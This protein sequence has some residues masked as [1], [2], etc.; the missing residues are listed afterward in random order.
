[1]NFRAG[2]RALLAVTAPLLLNT[3]ALSASEP[4]ALRFDVRAFEIEGSLPIPVDRSQAILV[5]FTG[6]AVGLEEL[7]AAAKALESELSAQG[8]V[9]YHVVL[10]PQT[11]GETVKLRVLPFALADVSVS[12]NK[13]FSNENVLASLPALKPGESPNVAAVARD[14][15]HSNEHPA[16]QVDVTFRQSQTPDSVDADV[17]VQDSRPL[18][19]YASLQN[20]GEDRTGDWRSTIGV[21]HGN[22]FNRDHALSASYTSSPGHW[23]DVRQYG[24]FYTAPFY[25]LGGSLTAFA[26]HSDVD[27]GTIAEAFNVSGGGDFVG[28]RWKQHLTPAGAYSHSLEL[29][30]EDRFF[31][32]GME[33]GS[34]DLGIDVRSR[35]VT[36]AYQGRIDRSGATYAGRLEYARNL[37]T[38]NHNND[39]AYSGNRMGAD[40]EWDAWRGSIEGNRAAGPWIL[41]ARIAGQYSDEPLI[42]GEQFGIGGAQSV[43]GLKERE[44]SGDK[45][46]LLTIEASTPLPWEG[47]R[48]AVFMDNGEVWI[49]NASAGQHSRQDAASVGVGLRWSYGGWISLV[50]DIAQVVD[51]TDATDSGHRRAHTA[52]VAQF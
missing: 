51:G 27:S 6:K 33:F 50:L 48:A 24:L 32:N 43:R 28:L 52:L 3:L 46:Y 7:Q 40:P 29:G 11:L 42:S 22:L 15:A 17:K 12:G 13:H 10:P 21:R 16:R 47:V 31:D 1:M 4:E 44:V 14:R 35:P 2:L 26:S 18:R 23:D 49:K 20:T 9:F 37:S 25:S 41:G 5:P 38:G 34:T 36:L 39:S 30:I 8:Y 45:G 19:V